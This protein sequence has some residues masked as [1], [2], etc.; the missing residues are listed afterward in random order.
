LGP[1]STGGVIGIEGPTGYVGDYLDIFDP[2]STVS[3]NTVQL[4][5]DHNYNV[6]AYGF[7]GNTGST[8]QSWLGALGNFVGGTSL[9]LSA[10]TGN[11][12]LGLKVSGSGDPFF[13]ENTGGSVVDY[14][15]AAGVF[16]TTQPIVSTLATGTAPLTVV[17]TTPVANL[18][19]QYAQSTQLNG[20]ASAIGGSS[21]SAG[22]CA[23][24]T[25]TITG[26]TTSM[27]VAVSPAADPGTGFTWEG[28]VSAAN[29]V[30]V[31]VCN[32][33]SGALTPV[34]AA[35]NVRVIQ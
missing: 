6:N 28:F 31:R 30:T 15:T 20:T 27:S 23:S 33:T 17:S 25:V 4:S 34:S 3:S 13:I 8:Q 18:T 14:F 10:S 26:A 32:V 19:A 24:G 2:T 29:T 21:L 22:Q 1:T 11:S 12:A 16:N 5:I 35:Y 7:H 9:E